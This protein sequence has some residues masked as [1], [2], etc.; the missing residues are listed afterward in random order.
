MAWLPKKLIVVPVDFSGKSVEAMTTALELAE[1]PSNVHAIHIVLPLESMSPKVQWGKI[2]D[3][4][5]EQAVREHFDEF[6]A[7]HGFSGVIATVRPGDPGTEIAEYASEVGAELIV[8]S[9]HGYHGLKRFLLGSVAAR[10]IR[11]ATCPVL[12]LRGQ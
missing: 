10:V 3:S 1:G 12:V 2:D 7:E 5:R 4:S 9:S 6:L 8:I 11:H